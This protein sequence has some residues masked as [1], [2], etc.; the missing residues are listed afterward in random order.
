MAAAGRFAPHAKQRGGDA[1][2]QEQRDRPHDQG[3]DHQVDALS[4]PQA[5]GAAASSTQ[6]CSLQHAGLQP[7][8]RRAAASSTQGCSLQRTG[9]QH[10]AHGATGF[11]QDLKVAASGTHLDRGVL[12]DAE[13]R[14]GK[15]RGGQSESREKEDA[16]GRTWALTQRWGRRGWRRLASASEA[17]A[18]RPAARESLL[19][20]PRRGGSRARGTAK[21]DV[22]PCCRSPV[23]GELGPE[24]TYHG[25]H[26]GRVESIPH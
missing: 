8:A 14:R 22:W 5:Q 2:T 21:Q 3:Q 4:G 26:Q 15:L 23:D 11:P 24:H 7:P 20:V 16:A 10:P 6:G 25:T 13:G 19:G 12:A 17:A 9:L 18:G 1:R